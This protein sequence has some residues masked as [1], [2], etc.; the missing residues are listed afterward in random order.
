MLNDGVFEIP[1]LP[2]Q[3]F[4][5]DFLREVCWKIF[6]TVRHNYCAHVQEWT[7]EKNLLF[8]CEEFQTRE[9]GIE[10]RC[11]LKESCLYLTTLKIYAKEL[12]FSPDI[13][14]P[15]LFSAPVCHFLTCAEGQ[16]V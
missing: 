5:L 3:N 10:V 8:E 4:R 2:Y 14:I 1:Q 16:D 7:S 12:L 15:T 11:S 6:A 9:K 13:G